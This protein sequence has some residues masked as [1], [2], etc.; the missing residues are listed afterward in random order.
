MSF[1][2][3]ANL[4]KGQRP[5]FLYSFRRNDQEFLFTNKKTEIIRSVPGITGDT[6]IPEAITHGNIIDTDQ[7]FRAELPISF[8][9]TNEF[10]F[11]QLGFFSVNPMKVRILKGFF[12][13]ETNELRAQFVGEVISVMIERTSGQITF[14]C[15]TD[16]AAL[17]RKGLSQV[18]QRPCRHSLYGTDCGVSIDDYKTTVSIT[19]I[20]PNSR[21]AQIDANPVLQNGVLRGGILIWQ[22]RY[23][24][25]DDNQGNILKLKE[26]LP[27]LVNAVSI[28][29][30]FVEIAP[31]CRLTR[32]D[33]NSKFNNILNF[34][35]FPWMSDNPFNGKQ[36]F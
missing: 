19:T 33:C 28:E 6:W 32:S 27:D 36:V 1:D 5:F 24:M 18:I 34:G 4:I 3:I 12:N 9:M 13:D 35:G 14:S 30:Q 29:S 25:I 17:E 26:N 23:S 2:A 8:P 22:G 7:A 31:G 20:T 10:A 21:F 11:N 16:I 15:M